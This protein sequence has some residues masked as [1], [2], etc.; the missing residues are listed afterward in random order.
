VG[1]VRFPT[2]N[3]EVTGSDFQFCDSV[4]QLTLD[5]PSPLN[6]NRNGRYPVPVP[7]EWTE[8]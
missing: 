7:G 2:Y 1:A 8:V 3:D 4:D 6:A 5:S